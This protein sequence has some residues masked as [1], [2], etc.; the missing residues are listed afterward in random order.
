MSAR[1]AT[2]NVVPYP[3]ISATTPKLPIPALETLSRILLLH[4]PAVLT[5]VKR[6]PPVVVLRPAG[7]H[8]LDSLESRLM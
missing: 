4:A 3:L 1:L 7:A 2:G 5:P 8:P 6:L